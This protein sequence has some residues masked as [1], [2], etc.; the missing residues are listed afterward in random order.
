M[1]TTGGLD[2]WPA[3]RRHPGVG[4]HR[5]PDRRGRAVRAAR[6]RRDPPALA[7]VARRRRASA[8]LWQAQGGLADPF[9]GN[10]AHRRLAA[11]HGATLRDN[12]PVTAIRDAGGGDLEVVTAGRD[13]PHAAG[14]PGRRRLDERAA[15]AVRPPPAA[16]DHQ[17]AGHL[18]RL[19]G[20][21]RLR[22]GP[23]PG[24]DLDGRPVLLRLPDLRRGGPEGRPGLRRRSRS[25]PTQ[26]T[27]D[28]DEAAF[29]RLGEF[30]ATHLPGAVGPP[31]YTKTCLYTLTPDRDFVVDRLP[32][33]PGVAVALGAAHGF[34]FASVLGRVLAELGVD[35]HDPVGRRDR[36]LPDRSAD[37]PRGRPG[38]VVDGLNT[39]R[40]HG[41]GHRLRWTQGC[42]TVPP[43]R[44]RRAPMRRRR[45]MRVSLRGRM[46]RVAA[47]LGLTA[48]LVLPAGGPGR[49]RRPV[50]LQDRDDPGPRLAQ[51]VPDGA[52]RRLRDLHPQLRPAGRLR[53]EPRAGPGL[54]RDLGAV[55]RRADLDVQDPR[56][57]EVVGRRARDRRGRRAGRSSTTSTRRR[58]KSASARL[59]RPV[60]HERGDHEG[61]GHR[62]DDLD[63]DDQPQERPHPPDVPADPAQAHLEG[64]DDRQGRRLRQQA[65]GRRDRSLPGRRVE[66]RRVGTAR[67]QPELLGPAGRRRRDHLP[68]LPRA[69]NAM[70]EAFKNGELDY[71]RN[72][73]GLQFDQLK[74]LPG[75][76]AINAAGN[77][78]TQ[79]NF[80]CYDKDIPDGGASTKA[81]RDPAFRAALGYAID[82]KALI[83]RV[84][85]GYGDDG[86]TQV[87]AWQRAWHVEPND[88]RQF[89]LTVAA[90]KLEEAGYPLKDGVRYRQGGQGPQ[91]QSDVPG[92][93]RLV[94]QGRPVHH[95]LVRPDR[96][97]GHLALDGFG[98]LGH[99]RVPRHD[100]PA[101]GPAQVRHG[102]LGLGRRPGPE[103]AAPDP[104]HRRDQR[105]ERQPVV[106]CGLRHAVHA[107][108]RG[109]RRATSARVS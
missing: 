38:D 28:R 52:G 91:P 68:V 42:A 20:P 3:E 77:G 44:A 7:A 22:A 35:G 53:A 51:S 67:P 73:T 13:L 108:E 60:R 21:G 96:D 94:P 39:I 27:F 26:R 4:L 11:A 87:P 74:T 46:A 14:R 59:P 100:D 18:L 65:A 76:V 24:L 50:V 95:R 17:G 47:V 81:F 88:V 40:A 105:F 29:A 6:R 69:T 80:N 41:A 37:P 99:D 93:R 54:R 63:G 9:K 15:R 32:D 109:G 30:M 31:I 5:Q 92:Q 12:A 48:A 61:Q 57:D 104:D 71:I 33:M 58:R 107:A 90:Q 85:N 97:Q 16:D 102:H 8:A 86:T 43:I 66:D 75:V 78:F 72:P 19:P 23:L 103:L 79:I 10:A 64:R 25:T 101:Q 82:R 1:T 2:L 106:E 89:D 84:L 34:K 45:R 70:V 62:S 36:P 83:T 55:R 98:D 56:R 49:G